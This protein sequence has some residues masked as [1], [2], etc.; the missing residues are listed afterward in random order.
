MHQRTAQLDALPTCSP[1]VRQRSTRSGAPA[2]PI[3]I[4]NTDLRARFTRLIKVGK[5]ASGTIYAD[6]NASGVAASLKRVRLRDAAEM[7]ALAFEVRCAST[8]RHSL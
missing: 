3:G 2:N 7:T 5:G 4:H 6:V 1:L 8:V